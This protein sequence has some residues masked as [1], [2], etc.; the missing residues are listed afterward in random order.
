[1]TK[2]GCAKH[3]APVDNGCCK[4]KTEYFK[5]DQDQQ[6]ENFEIKDFS[7]LTNSPAPPSEY[8]SFH[9]FDKLTI[10]EYLNFKP[11]LL[12]CDSFSLLQVF[13]L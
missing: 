12:I 10:P 6:V 11:P 1:M 13:L 8:L 4:D 9:L 2:S 3:R 7:F 5:L